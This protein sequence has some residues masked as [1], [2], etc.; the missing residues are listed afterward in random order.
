MY[1]L[2]CLTYIPKIIILLSYKEKKV[3]ILIIKILT[4]IKIL[5]IS[6]RLRLQW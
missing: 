6:V 1:F 5:P 3:K 2:F 4:I